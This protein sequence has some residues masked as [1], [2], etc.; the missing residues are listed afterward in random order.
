MFHFSK[1]TYTMLTFLWAF[2]I[3]ILCI[4]PG[5]D[6][7]QSSILQIDKIFHFLFYFILAFLYLSIFDKPNFKNIALV[8]FICIAYGFVIE[9]IQELFLADRF[10]DKF[11]VLANSTGAIVYG[12]LHFF[13][14]K[15]L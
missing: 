5:R 6:L 2:F 14:P 8:I 15:K 10:F 1:K 3:L 13:I 12:I 11:D 4:I 9:C 7:P